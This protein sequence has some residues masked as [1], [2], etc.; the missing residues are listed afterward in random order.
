MY[1]TCT[2]S[3]DPVQVGINPKPVDDLRRTLGRHMIGNC[4]LATAQNRTR[5]EQ[6][7]GRNG[8][9]ENLKPATYEEV[10]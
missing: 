3:S 10:L 5:N 6:G 1:L 7:K 8:H 2:D 4:C 9:Y